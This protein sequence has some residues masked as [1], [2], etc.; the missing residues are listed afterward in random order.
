[1]IEAV[2]VHWQC[3]CW[4]VG[5]LTGCHGRLP[6]HTCRRVTRRGGAAGGGACASWRPLL[7]PLRPMP[8][9]QRQLRRR[10]RAA[11]G[12][13][14][15]PSCCARCSTRLMCT[16]EAGCLRLACVGWHR[17]VVSALSKAGWPADAGL[18]CT[19][20]PARP[21]SLAKRH[22]KEV[23]VFTLL[24]DKTMLGQFVSNELIVSVFSAGHGWG[25]QCRH[26][27]RNHPSIPC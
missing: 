27:N 16:S 23:A 15:P 17:P 7:R 18:L 10:A 19:H 8:A 4:M 24:V 26:T 22:C 14:T 9:A 3:S 6:L 12:I 13:G 2:L 1:M 5:G 11:A 25:C 20:A 21:S